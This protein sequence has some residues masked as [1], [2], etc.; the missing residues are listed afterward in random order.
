MLA[1]FNNPDLNDNESAFLLSGLG[2]IISAKACL[3]P[4]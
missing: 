4:A 3:F 2:D 1:K